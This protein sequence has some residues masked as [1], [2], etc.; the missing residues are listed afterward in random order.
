[1]NHT[2]P[3][4]TVREFFQG[5]FDRFHRTLYVSFYDDRQFFHFAFFDLTEQIIQRN[6]LIR[7][8][9]FF[10]FMMFTLFYKFSCQAFIFYR[11]KD[12]ACRRNFC[13]TGNFDR[14]RWAGILN[15]FSLIVYHCPHSAHCSACDQY[16]TDMKGTVLHQN[17]CN[18]TASFIQTSFNNSAF[19]HTVRICF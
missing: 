10:F 2:Y 17:R 18:R 13:Q 19:C 8:K 6:F 15:A 1:M 3:H 14:S 9:Y 7:I 11:I 5:L 16:I 4:F 12:I